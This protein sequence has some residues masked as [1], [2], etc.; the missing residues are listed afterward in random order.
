MFNSTLDT[1]TGQCLELHTAFSSC[2]TAGGM[3]ASVQAR[4]HCKAIIR[5]TVFVYTARVEVGKKKTHTKC[6]AAQIMPCHCQQ[7]LHASCL[8]WRELAS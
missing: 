8:S 6:P 1:Q 7:S 2:G 4:A 3:A 5:M